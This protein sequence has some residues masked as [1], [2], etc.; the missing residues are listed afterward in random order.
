MSRDIK[1]LTM[2]GVIRIFTPIYGQQDFANSRRS[3]VSPFLKV[4]YLNKYCLY[5]EQVTSF[6]V[7][8]QTFSIG[9]L[10]G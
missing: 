5:P 4:E 1:L 2:E 7:Y 3:H 6:E 9:S 8:Q 10:T